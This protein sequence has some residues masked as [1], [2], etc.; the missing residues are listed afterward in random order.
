MSQCDR[1]RKQAMNDVQFPVSPKPWW[2]KITVVL[3][4]YRQG[5]HGYLKP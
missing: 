5:Q 1:I 2:T 4:V 3:T